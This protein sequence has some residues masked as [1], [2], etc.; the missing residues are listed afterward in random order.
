MSYEVAGSDII[1]LGI[2]RVEE[3]FFLLNVNLYLISSC[4]ICQKISKPVGNPHLELVHPKKS[5]IK[6]KTHQV[7]CCTDRLCAVFQYKD[8]K[9]VFLR[10]YE[11]SL[12][13]VQ[14]VSFFCFPLLFLRKVTEVKATSGSIF[15]NS[16]LNYESG[17]DRE[18][19]F[20]Q[21]VPAVM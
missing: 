16:S 12:A 7:R 1:S 17:C 20:L 11:I 8:I 5:R 19:P 13:Q 18:Q 10:G 6:C 3:G 2:I 14:Y 15:L 21:V 9:F 4:C